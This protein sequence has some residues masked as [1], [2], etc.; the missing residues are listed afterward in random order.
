MT[1]AFA[2]QS[3]TRPATAGGSWVFGR[4]VTL[5]AQPGAPRALQWLLARNCSITPRQLLTVYAG[6]CGASLLV[7]AFFYS[8]GATLV[9]PFAGIELVALGLALRIYGLHATDRETLTLVGPWLQVEQRC[10]QRV[11]RTDFGAAW[12]RV[13]P[14]AGQGSLVEL[15]GH[16][17]SVRVGRFLRPELRP[18]FARELRQALRRVSPDI[19]HASVPGIEQN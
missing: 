13:E 14:V 17:L 3:W 10:G 9:L 8:V 19:R 15:S 7:A 11:D 2:S 5:S 4:E 6:L 12:T 1:A 18:A 16:G